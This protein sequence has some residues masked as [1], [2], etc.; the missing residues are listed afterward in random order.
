MKTLKN[1]H[2]PDKYVKFHKHR[3]KKNNWIS[4]GILHSIKFRDNLYMKYK[5]CKSNSIEYNRHKQNLSVFNGIL[6]KTIRE[7]KILHYEKVFH[8]YRSDMKMTWKIISEVVCKSGSKRNEFDKI[9][10]DSK[11]ITAKISICNEFNSF[12]T[13]IGPKLADKINTQNKTC[14]KTYLKSYSH[15]SCLWLCWWKWRY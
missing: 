11:T 15:I 4:Y 12:F 14:Y 5:Q 6:K 8:E 3:H 10:V 9:I 7:A 1:K 13:S 2:M